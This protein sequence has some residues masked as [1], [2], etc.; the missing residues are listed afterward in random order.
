MVL[1]LNYKHLPK[2]FMSKN[3]STDYR[4]NQSIK[5]LENYFLIGKS[6][7]EQPYFENTISMPLYSWQWNKRLTAIVVPLTQLTTFK[8]LFTKNIVGI[9]NRYME[10]LKENTLNPFEY[11]PKEVTITVVESEDGY[12]SN[13]SIDKTLLPIEVLE[14]EFEPL[15]STLKTQVLEEQLAFKAL[16]FNEIELL[17]LSSYELKIVTDWNSIN[18]IP[19]DTVLQLINKATIHLRG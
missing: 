1:T 3:N 14:L 4:W 17:D 6:Y 9:N 5:T 8:T 11:Q 10:L 15:I 13:N 12:R 2:L 19:E 18:D 16:Y 7:K